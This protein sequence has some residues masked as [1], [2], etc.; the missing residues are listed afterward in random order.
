MRRLCLVQR[1]LG[2]GQVIIVLDANDLVRSATGRNITCPPGCPPLSS[3]AAP[4]ERRLSVLVVDDSIT[5]RT[6]EKNILETAGFDV[7]VAIDGEEA[8]QLVSEAVFRCGD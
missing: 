4:V 2:S 5:T 6:L 1:C 8:W 7:S 3:K